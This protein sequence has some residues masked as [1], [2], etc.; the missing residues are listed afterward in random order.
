MAPTD[1]QTTSGPAPVDV[2]PASVLTPL[3]E[4]CLR[5]TV[6][7]QALLERSACAVVS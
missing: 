6:A 3:E 2:P 7:L 1:A 5:V 4:D